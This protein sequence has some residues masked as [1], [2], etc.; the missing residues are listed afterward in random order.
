MFDLRGAKEGSVSLLPVFAVYDVVRLQG[1][2]IAVLNGSYVEPATWYTFDPAEG[3]VRD[4]ALKV[5][6]PVNFNDAL[7]ERVMVTSNDGTKVPLN[8]IRRKDAKLDGTN[9]TLLTGYGGYNVSL[10]PGFG[11]L[12]RL[13]LDQGGVYAS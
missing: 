9:P 3:K 8:I 7:V 2:T 12:R 1:D 11:T 10:K 4:T 13:W 6:M 5:A